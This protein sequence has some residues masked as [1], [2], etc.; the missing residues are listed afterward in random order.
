MKN[1]KY[2]IYK[3]TYGFE[4]LLKEN[5]Y[6]L[7]DV[8]SW[9]LYRKA[10]Y[11]GNVLKIYIIHFKDGGHACFSAVYFKSRDEYDKSALGLNGEKLLWW[12]ENANVIEYKVKCIYGKSYKYVIAM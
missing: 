1:I 11:C 7:E 9:C 5:R 3:K 12:Y 10:H 2:F 8:S 6:K 4:K